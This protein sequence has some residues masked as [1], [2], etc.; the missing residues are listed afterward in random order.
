MCKY[1]DGEKSLLSMSVQ[2]ANRITYGGGY[3]SDEEDF[4]VK[5]VGRKIMVGHFSEDYEDKILDKMKIDYCPKCGKE[6]S[7]RTHK[8]PEPMELIQVIRP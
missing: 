6:L 3:S 5:I 7:K 1:C 2:I 8:R 4:D